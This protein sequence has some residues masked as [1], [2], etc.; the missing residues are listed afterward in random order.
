V[1]MSEKVVKKLS[2]SGCTNII[3]LFCVVRRFCL[4]FWWVLPSVRG[5]CCCVHL[6]SAAASSFYGAVQHMLVCMGLGLMR[7]YP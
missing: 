4:L 6:L 2:Q 7:R 1:S 5:G 3:S